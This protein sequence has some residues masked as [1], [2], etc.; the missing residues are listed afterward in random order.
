M[1]A[2]IG[3]LAALNHRHKTGIGQKVDVAML[4]CQV[5]ILENAIA[6]YV[7]TGEVPKPA[8][9]KHASIVPFEPFETSDGEL[10]IA[11]G[12]DNLWGT[13]CKVSGLE[14]LTADPRFDTNAKRLEHYAVLRPMIAEAVI[15][16]T[17]AEWQSILD[18]A[19]VPNGP[20]NTV[21]KV[22]ENEQVLARDMI[23][24][25]EHPVAG[26]LKMPGIPVKLSATPGEILTPAPTLGQHTD[27]VLKEF[28]GD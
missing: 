3:I 27:E 15:A 16:K 26:K 12:N 2:A 28:L 4:D 17:T 25:V 7:V 6:R 1:F 13:F 24:E 14:V 22:I 21:D 9:N 20:I 8:G 18:K 23:V 11:V 5:A 10:M 19:G